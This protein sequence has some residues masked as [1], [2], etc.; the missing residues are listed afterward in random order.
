MIERGKSSAELRLVIVKGEVC[1]EMFGE[2]YETK[3]LFTLYGTLQLLRFYPGKVP[4]LD[5]FVL[6]GDKKRIKKTD[7]P[8]PNATSPPPLF[9]YCGEEEALDIV[10]PNWTF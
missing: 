10:F 5:L 1:M 6:T 8:G 9:H 3:D 2:P 4:N 7:Y